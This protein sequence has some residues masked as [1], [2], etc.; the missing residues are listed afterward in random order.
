MTS[1]AAKRITLAIGNTA[2]EY[3][4]ALKNLGNYAE[5]IPRNT[6]QILFRCAFRQQTIRFGSE[7][8]APD[9]N[10]VRPFRGESRRFAA[11]WRKPRN[12][13]G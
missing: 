5:G 1:L 11:K 9:R 2:Y 13:N 4:T 12:S 8:T 10:L 7:A 6:I 3:A